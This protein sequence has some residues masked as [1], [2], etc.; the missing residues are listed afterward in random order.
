MVFR[1]DNK[2]GDA[3]QRQMSA[4]RQQLGESSGDATDD[5]GT[6]SD[7]AVYPPYDSSE[8]DSSMG[9]GLGDA[10][11]RADDYRSYGERSSSLGGNQSVTGTIVPTPP[12]L[13]TLP[14][15][16][17]DTTVIAFNTIW[18]GELT[19]EGT[20]H[21]HGRLEGAIT[22]QGEIV[23]AERADV[24]ARLNAATVVVAGN[25]K[26]TIRCEQRFEALPTGRLT[27]DVHSPTLV[28]HEGAVIAGQVKMNMSEPMSTEP[29]PSD[30]RAERSD[31]PD[32]TG[33]GEREGRGETP[34]PVIQRR[35]NR[36]S[37]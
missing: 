14:E 31:R 24:D 29:S 19:S 18:K 12:D 21:V 3:F 2:S 25:V 5:E 32:R 13:P 35:V 27:G 23:I 7:S 22:A 10:V 16:D 1:R 17:A 34:V 28:I 4:L 20:V 11:A 37:A 30:D 26:G 36:G 9:G 8:S 6:E 15:I 33:R